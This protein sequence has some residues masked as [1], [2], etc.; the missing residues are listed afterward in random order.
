[1]S[2]LLSQ[3]NRVDDA[4]QSISNRIILFVWCIVAIMV[5][6]TVALYVVGVS[7][8]WVILSAGFSAIMSLW[9]AWATMIANK[10]KSVAGQVKK[11]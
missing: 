6:M 1:M 7:V 11:I 9:A 10:I 3:I 4:V 2:N 8:I 5:A